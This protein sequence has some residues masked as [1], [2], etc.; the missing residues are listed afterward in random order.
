MIRG[1]FSFLILSSG[2][3]SQENVNLGVF[4]QVAIVY[5]NWQMS[6]VYL[7]IVQPVVQLQGIKPTEKKMICIM[8]TRKPVLLGLS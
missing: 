6:K 3:N 1:F 7:V 5:M 8:S 2:N 4:D